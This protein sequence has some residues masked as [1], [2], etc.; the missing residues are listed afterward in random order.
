ME[1]ENSC[2]AGHTHTHTR[3][4]INTGLSVLIPF[5][6]HIILLFLLPGPLAGG[7]ENKLRVDWDL[8]LTC[9]VTWLKCFP[10]CTSTCPQASLPTSLSEYW[11]CSLTVTL[12][13]GRHR[14]L[15]NCW[16]SCPVVQ[17]WLDSQ[18]KPSTQPPSPAHWCIMCAYWIPSL[19]LW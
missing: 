5:A 1:G 10:A 2:S 16:T 14:S 4:R 18:Q 8:F 9:L 19:R 17:S 13:M 7:L 6:F 15:C 11:N 3:T 12:C